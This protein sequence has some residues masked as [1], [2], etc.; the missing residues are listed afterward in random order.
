MENETVDTQQ[1]LERLE[2]LTETVERRLSYIGGYCPETGDVHTYDDLDMWSLWT[3]V[4]RYPCKRCGKRISKSEKT[5]LK[6]GSRILDAI[7]EVT[8]D[9]EN[10]FTPRSSDLGWS[11]YRRY[12]T[13]RNLLEY[14]VFAD[15]DEEERRTLVELHDS[16][17][18]RSKVT[19]VLEFAN[20][21]EQGEI[22]HDGR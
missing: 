4:G 12:K 17:L 10:G 2:S 9:V 6:D 13:A 16:D 22:V 11:E 3:A 8:T 7:E 20:Q 21:I 1:V 18:D 19:R 15:A 5:R 14:D